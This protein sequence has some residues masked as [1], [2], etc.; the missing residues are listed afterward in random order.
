MN[1]AVPALSVLWTDRTRQDEAVWAEWQALHPLSADLYDMTCDRVW[2][3]PE[4][5]AERAIL[6]AQTFRKLV[7]TRS[8]RQHLAVD[9]QLAFARQVRKQVDA[10]GG[11]G[12]SGGGSV[13]MFLI[14]R[15]A[16]HEF[17]LMQKRALK[18]AK[19]RT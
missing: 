8:C 10:H 4:L 3:H 12:K 14:G 6:W 1:K 15:S 2:D 13:G 19:A 5:S 18:G 7:L 9:Q 16:F 17:K 11:I